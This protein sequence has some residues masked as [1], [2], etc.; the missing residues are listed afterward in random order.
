MPWIRVASLIRVS[1][2]MRSGR[3]TISTPPGDGVGVAFGESAVRK[4]SA[5]TL[6]TGASRPGVSVVARSSA[7]VR[8]AARAAS[9]RSD[10]RRRGPPPGPPGDLPA[11]Q[12]VHPG[13]EPGAQV[14]RFRHQPCHGPLR[15]PGR[16]RQIG[17][18]R[19]PIQLGA[20]ALLRGRLRRPATAAAASAINR[21]SAA[22]A[23]ARAR[24]PASNPATNR[25]PLTTSAG[26]A[27]SPE[28]PA[29]SNAGRQTSDSQTR[30]DKDGEILA[31]QRP[32]P[33]PHPAAP[34]APHPPPIARSPL[35]Y[36][37]SLNYRLL[38][39]RV[40][41]KNKYANLS[42]L[43]NQ[44]RPRR[45]PLRGA[46]SVIRSAPSSHRDRSR[47]ARGVPVRRRRPRTARCWWSAS[48]AATR[49]AAVGGDREA[50]GLGFGHDELLRRRHR[51]RPETATA[52]SVLSVRSEHH[53]WDGSEK[54]RSAPQ[55]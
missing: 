33:C 26:S 13:G 39:N 20:P 43:P 9:S 36:I 18:Q 49:Y 27:P 28:A 29:A 46:H 10:R 14:R 7:R 45:S 5:I 3:S 8:N 52:P 22:S 6:S 37:E 50:A 31:P 21:I 15:H 1:A 32:S 24:R 53:R 40:L 34:A 44:L 4:R 47:P 48:P 16:G 35:A 38:S 17:D 25:I 42:S 54:C 41:S 55:M 12:R 11:L 30:T 51:P 2:A 19:P 23:T